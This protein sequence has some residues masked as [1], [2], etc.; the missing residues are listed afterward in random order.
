MIILIYKLTKPQHNQISRTLPYCPKSLPFW[1]FFPPFIDWLLVLNSKAMG[2]SLISTIY[3]LTICISQI[4][5]IRWGPEWCR[6]GRA[7]A[8][9]R[10]DGAGVG[11]VLT[12]GEPRFDP[13]GSPMIL[14][15]R[16]DF[17]VH[18]YVQPLSIIR[19]GLKIK[20]RGEGEETSYGICPHSWVFLFKKLCLF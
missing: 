10:S 9:P 17:C 15:T 20:E 3:S 18:S 12:H 6:R 11:H 4:R 2:L 7:R 14:Q 1:S 16:S 5:N 19:R 13:P 8:D